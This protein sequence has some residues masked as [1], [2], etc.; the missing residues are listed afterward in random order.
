MIFFTDFSPKNILE[1]FVKSVNWWQRFVDHKS[2]WLTN[3]I[4]FVDC[5][6]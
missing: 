4:V 5:G 1:V 2:L 3:L 6:R